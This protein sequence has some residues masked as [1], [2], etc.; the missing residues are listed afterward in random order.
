ML[1]DAESGVPVAELVHRSSVQQ[2][3]GQLWHFAAHSTSRDSDDGRRIDAQR[4]S[5]ELVHL[6]AD[7]GADVGWTWQRYRQ[8]FLYEVEQVDRAE[9]VLSGQELIKPDTQARNRR[10]DRPLRSLQRIG[11]GCELQLAPLDVS[12]CAPYRSGTRSSPAC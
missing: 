7:A 4:V 6:G 2:V 9:Q 12:A 1:K 8:L 3:V 10:E 5:P 11:V